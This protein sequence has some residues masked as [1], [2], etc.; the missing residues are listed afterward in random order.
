MFEEPVRKTPPSFVEFLEGVAA[1]YAFG[2]KPTAPQRRL[3][4]QAAQEFGDRLTAL[5]AGVS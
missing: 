4:K 3:A 1:R 5:R 2:E